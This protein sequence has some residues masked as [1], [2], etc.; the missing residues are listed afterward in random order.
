MVVPHRKA[1]QFHGEIRL[2]FPAHRSLGIHLLPRESY[3][4][5]IPLGQD[6]AVGEP[7]FDH[8]FVIKGYN[9]AAVIELLTPNIRPLLLHL[10]Q[11]GTI[12]LDDICFR[13]H[14]TDLHI[15]R[16]Q[17]CIEDM[18]TIAQALHWQYD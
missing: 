9:R 7:D 18:V 5:D 6:I 13:L 1:D 11:F 16:I 12:E 2:F 17:K 14:H 15:E 3:Q 4:E 10:Q 8:H